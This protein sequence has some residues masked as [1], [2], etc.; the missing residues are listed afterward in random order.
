MS[1]NIRYVSDRTL[2]GSNIAIYEQFIKFIHVESSTGENLFFV[3]KREIQSLEL[4]INNIRG[5][6]YDNGSNMKGKVSGVLAR[7]LK[8]NP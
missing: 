3:L 1:L 2:P 7:L 6:G 8:E 4:H 5:Q